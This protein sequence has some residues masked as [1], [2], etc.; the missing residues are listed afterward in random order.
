MA[1]DLGYCCVLLKT[2]VKEVK[3][4]DYVLVK[5]HILLHGQVLLCTEILKSVVQTLFY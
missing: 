4:L 5:H 1:I 3:K 2:E